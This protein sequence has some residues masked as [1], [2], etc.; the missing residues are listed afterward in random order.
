MT[1]SPRNTRASNSGLPLNISSTQKN[2]TQTVTV[3]NNRFVAKLYFLII[4]NRKDLYIV[5]AIVNT[6]VKQNSLYLC[7]LF[8]NT[9][10]RV[11]KY[12]DCRLCPYHDA[13]IIMC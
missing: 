12:L 10:E 11:Y 5:E 4:V 1:L 13:Y 9:A 6:I 7:Y 2:T 3:L 8:A